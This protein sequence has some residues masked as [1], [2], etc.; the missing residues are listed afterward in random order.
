[1][2]QIDE[3]YS[4]LGCPE[5]REAISAMADGEASPSEQQRT[6]AHLQNCPSCQVY[7]RHLQAVKK[8]LNRTNWASLWMQAVRENQKL[9]RWLFVAVVGAVIVSVGLT[10]TFIRRFWRTPLMTPLVAAAIYRQHL[11]VPFET[12]INLSC[13]MAMKCQVTNAL[14]LPPLQRAAIESQG[15]LERVG[16]CNCAGCPVAVYQLKVRANPVMILQFNTN[17]LPLK[18][19]KA[20]KITSEECS[21]ACTVVAGLHMLLW[22]EGSCGVALIVPEGKVNPFPIVRYIQTE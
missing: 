13:Q 19:D 20:S 4:D 10:A 3:H 8:R 6:W 9:R 16:I 1:M 12:P 15:N 21:A 7:Y 2:S 14:H 5:W 22:Q 18:V 11:Q 17:D